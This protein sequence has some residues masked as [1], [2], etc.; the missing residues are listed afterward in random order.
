MTPLEFITALKPAALSTQA[1]TGIPASFTIAQAALESAWGKS[2]LTTQA[3][4]LFGV[5]ADASWCGD[6]L[7][8]PT[9][10]CLKGEWVTVLAKWRKYKD[11]QGC[12]DDHAAFLLKNSRY[13]PAF[14]FKTGI[15]FAQA[16]ARAGYATDPAYATKIAQIITANN[17]NKLDSA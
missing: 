12:I 3:R 13:K 8:L 5:K 9:Q 11:W 4:N 6:V 10:E 17:L 7:S 1:K 16:V 15:Q 2:G 14:A